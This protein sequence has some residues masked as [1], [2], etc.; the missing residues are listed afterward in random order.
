MNDVTHSETL[1]PLP[2]AVSIG[3]RLDALK[4]IGPGFDHLRIG[5]S[6]GILFVHSFGV[7]YGMVWA[8][9]Q[10]APSKAFIAML[11][12]MFFALSG[13][14][15]MGSALRIDSLKTFITFRVLRIVPAL[16]TEISLSALI[17]GPA[18]TVLPL[19]DYFASDKLPA[20]FGSLI[21]RVS[22][23]LPGLFLTNPFPEMVNASLWTVGPE[24]LCYIVASLLILAG[25]FRSARSMAVVALLF[26][27]LCIVTDRWDH[28]VVGEVLPTK[29]LILSFLLGNIL[30]LIRHFVPLGLGYMALALVITLVAIGL[31][32]AAIVFHPLMYLAAAGSAYLVAAIG[33]QQ[34]PRLPF[35]HRGDYSYG[36]YIYGFPI[37]QAIVYFLPSIRN[38]WVN[39]AI[40]LPLTLT[41][42]VLSWHYVEKPV[43]GLRKRI[44]AKAKDAPAAS[45]SRWS[46]PR[47][48]LLGV[49]LICYGIFV[50]DAA[51]IFPLRSMAHSALERI[52]IIEHRLAPVAPAAPGRI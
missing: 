40:A 47:T 21:G 23:V 22:F 3:A 39:F 44:L 11:L 16:A 33:V 30:Y 1:S 24:I 48:W 8:T 27:A 2:K 37:Q 15:I 12:P 10:P 13:F 25:L 17:L 7:N 5:L 45:A 38:G 43:L 32:Q 34:L 14:L 49:F 28:G 35:F 19:A 29:V 52:G 46:D 36:I 51:A 9:S 42:A 26:V 6:I 4:G 18:L 50:A 31:S 20:Y 41:L